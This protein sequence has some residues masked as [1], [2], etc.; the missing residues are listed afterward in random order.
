MTT[1][2]E[3]T[4]PYLDTPAYAV[5]KHIQELTSVFLNNGSESDFAKAYDLLTQLSKLRGNLNDNIR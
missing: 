2:K 1:L 5:E 4:N 3:A